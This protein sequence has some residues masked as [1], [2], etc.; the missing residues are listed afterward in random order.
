MTQ[1]DPWLKNMDVLCGAKAIGR[2]VGVPTNRLYHLV[3][4][5]NLPINREGSTRVARR[6]ALKAWYDR[7]GDDDG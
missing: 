5:P 4:C 6:S 1:L 3:R 2:F 7:G